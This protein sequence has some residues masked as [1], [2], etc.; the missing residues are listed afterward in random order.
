MN[1]GVGLLPGGEGKESLWSHIQDAEVGVSYVK[2]EYILQGTVD[3]IRGD[4]D[5]VEIVDFKSEKKPDMKA[6]SES[7]ERYRRQLEV[8]AYLIEE[9]LGKKVSRMHL[10]YT[11]EDKGEPIV[12]FEKSKESID[13]TIKAFDNVVEKIQKHDF[14]TEA[15]NKKTCLNCDM[16]Y[17]C[18]K[19]S[20]Q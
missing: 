15:K 3:L 2:P 19:V 14:S 1:S 11:G 10:Y 6:E 13:I 16:R 7:F 8:Y 18:G 4:G 17:Y 9:R 12:T 5:S 20:K